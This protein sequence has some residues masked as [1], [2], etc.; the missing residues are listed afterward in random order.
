MGPLYFVF[1]CCV[2]GITEVNDVYVLCSIGAERAGLRWHQPGEAR[3]DARA[4]NFLNR[5][6]RLGG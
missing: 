6:A 4:S 5:E 2:C 3:V 1:H